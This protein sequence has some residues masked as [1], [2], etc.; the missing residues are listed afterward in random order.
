MIVTLLLAVALV[1]AAIDIV[2][3]QG[4]SLTAWA[5]ALIAVALLVGRLG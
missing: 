4:Q 5:A 1:L 2:R 3:S